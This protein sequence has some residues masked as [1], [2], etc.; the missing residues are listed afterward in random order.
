MECEYP[1]TTY[2]PE[3]E[4]VS[5]RNRERQLVQ[6]GTALWKKRKEELQRQKY[7]EQREL[8]EMLA[9]YSP[10]GRP[11]GGA[12]CASALRKKNVRL[13][14]ATP[15]RNCIY[16]DWKKN[17]TTQRLV[18]LE[19]IDT[20]DIQPSSGAVDANRFFQMDSRR[21][22][23][24][25]ARNR[26]NEEIQIYKLTGGVELVPLLT[27]R[28]HHAQPQTTRYLATDA[29]RPGYTIDSL[30]GMAA[31][32]VNREYVRDLGEQIRYKRERI[33]EER[34]REQE[35]SRKHFDTW[36][37]FWGRPGHGA[38]TQHLYRTNLYDILYRVAL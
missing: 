1:G 19:P 17:S 35:T 36:R 29:T 14:P 23:S 38:P 25:V 4:E 28:R 26:N 10:W 37:R 18:K 32:S 8:R 31:A 24:F 13:E 22:R 2:I 12:P 20:R 30:R 33:L 3:D 11:G 9:S 5:R 15:S 6:E 7:R 34:R 21:G 27:T 16:E